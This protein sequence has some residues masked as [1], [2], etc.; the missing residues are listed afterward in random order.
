MGG[1]NGQRRGGA[2]NQKLKI[3]GD[4]VVC[5]STDEF[6]TLNISDGSANEYFVGYD[7]VLNDFS[8]SGG[9]IFACGKEGLLL[10]Y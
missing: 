3:L 8:I 4:T 10:E 5:L 2:G 1:G 7:S 6:V 9:N